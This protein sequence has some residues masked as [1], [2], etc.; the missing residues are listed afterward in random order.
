MKRNKVTI[1]AEAGVNHNGSL[2]LAKKLINFA[3]K[4][5]ADFIKFQSFKTDNLV[6]DNTQTTKYQRVN[7]KKK[8]TQ[9]SLLKK[10]EL[11][12]NNH[13]QII[14][15]CKKKGIKSIFSPFDLESLE[16]LFRLKI[17]NIKIASGEINNY[18]LLKKIAKK[19]KKIILSTGMSTL[20]EVLNAIKILKKNGA[21]QKIISVLHCHSDYPTNLKNV[22][23]NAMKT[24]GKKTNLA[25]GYSDHTIGIETA[26]ASVALGGTVIEKHITLNKKMS[27]PDHKASM[28]FK[29][30]SKYVSLIRNTES[31]LGSYK[32][33]P[34]KVEI[35]NKK[36]IRKSIV[37][38][39][40]IKKGEFFSEKNITS[41]R[42]EGGISPVYWN[43]LIG[44]KSKRSFNINEFISLK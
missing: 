25:V 13:K 32:K 7:T 35:F 42:P 27:G 5:G 28:D 30:F 16:M 12:E 19:A 3:K 18:F 34:T 44:K 39:R 15:Y 37:A 41:K 26:I 20:S 11:S 17:F 31:L 14:S 4:S 23:L 8:E 21:K 38:K 22:N 43:Y 29:E 24:L 9:H 36:L 2:L 1:I 10:L 6:K 33:K 40:S